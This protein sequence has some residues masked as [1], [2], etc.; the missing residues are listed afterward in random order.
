MKKK[1]LHSITAIVVLLVA[2]ET[3][4][5]HAQ[6]YSTGPLLT[7]AEATARLTP[8]ETRQTEAYFR[9]NFEHQTTAE[10]ITGHFRSGS[11]IGFCEERAV[12]VAQVGMCGNSRQRVIHISSA[13]AVIFLA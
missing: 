6:E 10:R 11:T 1:L 7:P 12:V 9:F 4:N 8:E 13:E 3:N 2:M 5:T